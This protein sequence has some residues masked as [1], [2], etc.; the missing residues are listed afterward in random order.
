MSAPPGEVRVQERC[1][2][3]PPVDILLPREQDTLM[4][5]P[6]RSDRSR[7]RG[8]RR[9]IAQGEIRFG[10]EEKSADFPDAPGMMRWFHLPC[11]ADAHPH[12]LHRELSDYAN[13]IADRDV[14][15]ARTAQA[16]PTRPFP[17]SEPWWEAVE[18]GDLERVR[19]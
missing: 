2:S 10:F 18:A 14:L 1:L 17:R 11:A 7:C 3:Q 5:E 16:P 13:P 9:K 15:L 19:T 12:E 4:I 8:C 6:A